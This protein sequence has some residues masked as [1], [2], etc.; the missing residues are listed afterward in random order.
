MH[1]T[2][3]RAM[4]L[5]GRAHWWAPGRRPSPYRSSLSTAARALREQDARLLGQ[6]SPR[7]APDTN[8]SAAFARWR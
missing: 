1:K 7:T 6:P 4:D 5:M 3:L 2:L 8:P